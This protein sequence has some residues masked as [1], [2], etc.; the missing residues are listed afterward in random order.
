MTR[1]RAVPCIVAAAVRVPASSFADELILSVA[2]PGRHDDVRRA[3]QQLGIELSSSDEHQGFL[4]SEGLFVRRKLALAIAR[5]AGQL[6]HDPKAPHVG[7]FS[8]DVW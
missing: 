1:D 6:I 5:T 8:E 2:S 3:A 7:L 4:T